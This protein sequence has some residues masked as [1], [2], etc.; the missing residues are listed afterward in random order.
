MRGGDPAARVHRWLLVL[1]PPAFRARFGAEL[2]ATFASAWRRAR[3]RGGA[4][5]GRFLVVALIDVVVSAWGERR[6]RHGGRPPWG[7]TAQDLR[8]AVRGLRR[9][10]GFAAAVIATLALGIGANAAVFSLVDAVLLDPV[11]VREPG[12]VVA[13]FE[14]RNADHYGATS[15]PTFTE[16]REGARTLSG[17]AVSSEVDAGLRVGDV[18]DRVSAG[19]V[20]GNWFEVMGVVPQAG[21]LLLPA[22]EEN[23][24]RHHV[25]LSDALWRRHFGADPRVVGQAIE[26]TGTT[27]TVVGVAPAGFRG[28]DLSAPHDLWLPVVLIREIG[29]DGLWGEDVLTTRFLPFLRM[30]GRLRPGATA[31]AVE[32]EL[33][34]RHAALREANG[35]EMDMPFADRPIHTLPIREAAALD[36]RDDLIRFLAVP[37]A[38]AVLTL[39]IACLNVALLLLVRASE[40][41]QEFGI[42]AA[43]GAGRGRLVRQVL[44]ESVLIGA[45]GGVVG[46]AVAQATVA[47]LRRFPL[48]G[49]I[50]MDTLRLA[51]DARMLTFGFAV[52]LGT[53]LV[54]GSVPAW[55]AARADL[56]GRLKSG[57]RTGGAES[58]RVRLVL[59]TGQV[60]LC[61]TLLVGAGLFL[62]SLRAALDVEPGFDARGL[63]AASFSLRPHGYTRESGPAFIRTVLERVER[64]PG[65]ES[66][67]LGLHVPIEPRRLRMPISDEVIPE[68]SGRY[69][70]AGSFLPVNVIAG[71]WF[72]A[73]RIPVLRGRIFGP[74]DGPGAPPVAVLGRS[75]AAE[76]WPGEDPIG[77]QLQLVRGVGPGVTV[78]GIVADITAHAVQEGAVPY[79]YLSALQ[80]PQIQVLSD[81]TL[82]ARDGVGGAIAGAAIRQ[83]L[84]TEDPTLPVFRERRVADQVAAVLVPQR[85]GSTLLGIFG[86]VALL[87]AAVGIYGVVAYAVA[88]RRFEIGLRRALGARP[89]DIIRDVTRHTA[90]AVL[91]GTVA[92]TVAAL[93]LTR[94]ID[95]FLFGIPAVDPVAY[96][97]AATLI[98]LTALAATLLP[99]RR[100]T[101][102]SPLTAIRSED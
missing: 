27:F 64:M 85:L 35:A 87:V 2:E 79:V 95:A 55:A 90:L 77:R 53:A 59:L 40:R 57:T 96:A 42:R 58:G 24:G 46:I 82:I 18:S 56:L 22:D 38:V 47:L 23:G 65:V 1:Y 100:A 99:A 74:G 15:W 19:V 51:P 70:G 66:S 98:A 7:G 61:L 25:V 97:A 91:L 8:H 88:R 39:L 26:L 69:G 30:V 68:G 3:S 21:R 17:L 76:L 86:V 6:E 29:G 81:A 49:G 101:R 92:G 31:A 11:P 73:L 10:P 48:P 33:N 9:R 83:A 16:L 54:F 67:A 75:A 32:E 12:S 28:T 52:A 94:F 44:T 37:A 71:D 84:A 62:R 80:Y 43:L 5:A 14:A 78:I 45:A 20:S 89:R 60:A 4:S 102:V 72:G 63:A 93:W 13:V 41:R 36:R 34:V 50:A